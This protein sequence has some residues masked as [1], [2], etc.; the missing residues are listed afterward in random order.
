MRR[1]DRVLVVAVLNVTPD[2][3]FEGSRFMSSNEAIDRA[4]LMESEGAD[5][6]DVGGESSRPGSSPV[7]AAEELNRV[8]PIVEGIRKRSDVLISVDTTKAAVAS[9]A[10]AAGASI[11]ND[12]SALR[13]DPDMA[14]TVAAAGAF[15]VLM[16]MQGTP[17]TMQQEPTYANVVNEVRTFLDER[18]CAAAAAGISGDRV[19]LDPGVGFGKRLDHNLELLRNLDRIVE[20]GP[21]VM[22]GASRKSFLGEILG[23]PAR[24]RL[25]GT[26]VTNSVAIVRGA[27]LIRVHDAKEGRRTA[28]VA[29]RLRHHAD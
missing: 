5:V 13:F 18:V 4:L 17:A 8:L 9:S 15:V 23:L 3:F 19:I 16:H 10:L 1:R 28:D 22:I 12:I 11:V 2:S 20:L 14:G 29:R 25:E 6:I 26:I 21:P 27:D 7:S 24:D